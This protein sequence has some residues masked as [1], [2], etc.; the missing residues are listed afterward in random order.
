MGEQP[1]IDFTYFLPVLAPNLVP[2]N[3][4]EPDTVSSL[5]N[6]Y[7]FLIPFVVGHNAMSTESNKETVRRFRDALN[8]GDLD[9]AIAVFAPDAIV[10]LS[11]S[12][13]P[14]TVDGF[15]QLGAALRMAFPDG[16][17]NIEDLIAEGDMV[18]SR[19]TYRATH[20]GDLMGIPPTGKSVAISEVIIN[21]FAGGR[22]IESWRFFDQMTMMQQL[23]VVPT[24]GQNGS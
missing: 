12:P 5:L 18:V 14:L 24:P 7:G 16:K 15:K 4:A 6:K 20:T 2:P 22:I 21:R 19:L 17:G 13:E 10:H 8:A 9:G 3:A 1:A 11:S 23:G